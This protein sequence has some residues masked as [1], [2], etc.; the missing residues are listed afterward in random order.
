MNEP[1]LFRAAFVRAFVFLLITAAGV[2]AASAGEHPAKSIGE[3]SREEI[4]ES[5]TSHAWCRDLDGRSE[6]PRSDRARTRL[7]LYR[8]GTADFWSLSYDELPTVMTPVKWTFI[9]NG[10]A[11][12]VLYLADSSG[13]L[14]R[15]V[16][17]EFVAA[18]A[19][20]L[21]AMESGR[22]EVPYLQ[23]EPLAGK[24]QVSELPTIPLLPILDELEGTTWKA[25]SD[26]SRVA[27]ASEVRFWRDGR[28]RLT[29]AA[30]VCQRLF[31]S[32]DR[33]GFTPVRGGGCARVVPFERDYR[34]SGIFLVHHDR[35]LYAPSSEPVHGTS[36]FLPF[37]QDGFEGVVSYA[38]PVRF[39]LNLH[40]ELWQAGSQPAAI[41]TLA[42]SE[43]FFRSRVRIR[44]E[45]GLL[46]VGKRT[47]PDAVLSFDF[48]IRSISPE[49]R[50][51]ALALVIDHL[52]GDAATP[53]S[54]MLYV[55]LP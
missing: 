53:N 48:L 24:G 31:E 30:S 22:V 9:K 3:M 8:N 46:R 10:P 16:L 28:V 54:L 23:C 34:R 47:S 37:G 45:L 26:V 38:R 39:P 6:P 36:M 15:I 12:G 1:S 41:G 11:S 40:V 51:T 42:I 49:A 13:R 52:R 43:E 35:D 5:L 29:Y 20:R 14:G 2:S 33:Y 17:F 18:D 27:Q 7:R 4:F 44:R 25:V 55:A 19:L 21:N 32:G 50:S